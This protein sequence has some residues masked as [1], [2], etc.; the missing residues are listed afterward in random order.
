M[1]KM[2]TSKELQQIY[3]LSRAT[4]DRWRREG[5]PSIKVGRGVRFEEE[6]VKKWIEENKQ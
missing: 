1:G 5:M 4:I 3:S 2:I 6:T